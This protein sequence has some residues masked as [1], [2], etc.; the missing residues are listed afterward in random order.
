MEAVGEGIS[1]GRTRAGALEGWGLNSYGGGVG[2]LGRPR[3]G[4]WRNGSGGL[5]LNWKWGSRR[6]KNWCR[7]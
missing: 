7:R 6:M 2:G 4:E 1:G 5:G 3:D